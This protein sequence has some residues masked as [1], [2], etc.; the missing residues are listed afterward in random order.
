MV[1]LACF[2]RARGQERGEGKMERRAGGGLLRRRSGPKVA[3]IEVQRRAIP[4]VQVTG[5]AA[6]GEGAGAVVPKRSCRG[7]TFLA[8]VAIVLRWVCSSMRFV[9]ATI[10]TILAWMVRPLVLLWKWWRDLIDDGHSDYLCEAVCLFIV[11]APIVFVSTLKAL[12][13]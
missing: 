3:E 4:P 8:G 5:G 13:E 9:G 1:T 12:L 2:C 7:E 11:L 10:F 6:V